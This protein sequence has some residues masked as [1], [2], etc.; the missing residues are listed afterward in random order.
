MT[1]LKVSCK[2][3]E[4]SELSDEALIGQLLSKLSH[5]KYDEKKMDI[6]KHIMQIQSL[7][8]KLFKLGLKV[9]DPILTHFIFKG[10]PKS[11]RHSM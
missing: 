8:S 11:L 10:L 6:A 4:K 7:A 9:K 5:L 2:L 1:Y 3:K